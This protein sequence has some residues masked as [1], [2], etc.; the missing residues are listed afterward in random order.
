MDS[1]TAVELPGLLE[2][3]NSADQ[4]AERCAGASTFELSN[5]AAISAKAAL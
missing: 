5:V 2:Y 1:D 3:R 4:R